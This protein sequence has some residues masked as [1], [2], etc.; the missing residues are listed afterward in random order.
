M[1]KLM[2]SFILPTLLLVAFG[3]GSSE[4]VTSA[5]P[6]ARFAKAKELYDKRDYLEAINEFTVLTLQFQGSSVAADAQFYLGECRFARGE[7]LL[8]GFEYSVLKRSFPASAR[9]PESQY[10]L[11]VSYYDLSP[12][13]SLDQQY[14]RKAVEEL[15]AFIE[16]YPDDPHVPDAAAKI[17]EL[18]TKLAEKQYNTAR[19]Y[20][21]MEYYRAALSTYDMVIEKYHD[22]EYAPLAYIEKCELLYSR[23]RYRE[24]GTEITKFLERYPNSVLASR[25]QLLK[26]KIAKEMPTS[27]E[28]ST[29]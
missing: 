3:C 29:K 15:Q 22:T 10:K 7:Y 13:A 25:A 16:Y 14:T 6:E 20:S 21:R 9:V 24:A 17:K 28:T 5:T 26:G 4:T 12:P 19:L 18:N 11:G 1:V 8:A 27:T 2:L 23:H